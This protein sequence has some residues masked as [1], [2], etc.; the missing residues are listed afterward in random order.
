[1]PGQHATPLAGTSEGAPVAPH[2]HGGPTVSVLAMLATAG[3][4]KEIGATQAGAPVV[5]GAV[6]GAPVV[7]YVAP[8]PYVVGRPFIGPYYGP[9]WRGYGPGYYGPRYYRGGYGRRW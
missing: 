4:R 6:V 1:M 7:P 3:A 9:G 8:Y 2:D 5:G